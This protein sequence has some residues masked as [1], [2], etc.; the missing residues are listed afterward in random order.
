M[1]QPD[2]ERKIEITVDGERVRGTVHNGGA[3]DLSV[4]LDE[5]V[6]DW[7]ISLHMANFARPVHP[8]G[9]L[10]EY[11][12]ERALEL[13]VNLY[14]EQKKGD[15]RRKFAG[16]DFEEFGRVR[17]LGVDPRHPPRHQGRGVKIR[18]KASV[19]PLVY[20]QIEDDG[21]YGRARFFDSGTNEPFLAEAAVYEEDL[22]EYI[23]GV[24]ADR[25]FSLHLEIIRKKL[26]PG[27]VRCAELLKTYRVSPYQVDFL[28]NF[29]SAWREGAIALEAHEIDQLIELGYMI[30]DPGLGANERVALEASL[31]R[32]RAALENFEAAGKEHQAAQCRAKVQKLESRIDAKTLMITA[33]GKSV[34]KKLPSQVRFS[35]DLS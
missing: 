30:R 3:A 2:S 11:G 9:F 22:K 31:A 26:L 12:E 17:Y 5:P 6:N 23:R 27:M 1:H 10:G 19:T 34:A 16:V 14:R 35:D 15:R 21:P 28:Q 32:T 20:V 24:K 4:R 29:G 18:E 7:T 13:L 25:G 8:E 33:A